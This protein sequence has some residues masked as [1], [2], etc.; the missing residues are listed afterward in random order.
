MDLFT[1]YEPSRLWICKPCQFAVPPKN[2][3]AH[4]RIRHSIHPTA[5]TEALRQDAYQRMSKRP[6]LDPTPEP[7]IYP[8]AKSPPI[9][10]LPV[11]IGYQ[12]PQCSYILRAT[13]VLSKH[14]R[15]THPE[16]GRPAGRQ[17]ATV[18]SQEL[19]AL[20]GDSRLAVSGS[21]LQPQAVASS[22]SARVRKSSGRSKPRR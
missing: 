1:Y 17:G 4:L 22:P 6:W 12:C 14:I 11:Y 19:E 7:C 21:F 10:N 16:L 18:R 8:D 15:K 20:T 3:Q 2:L 9:P 5:T 13:R